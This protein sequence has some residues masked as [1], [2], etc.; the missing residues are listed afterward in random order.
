MFIN[1]GTQGFHFSDKGIKIIEER[2][3]AKYMG[4][5][6]T[7]HGGRWQ[8]MPVDVFYVENPDTSKG[9]TNFFGM[10]RKGENVLIT[11]ASSCFAEPITG[12]LTDTGEVV[13]SRYRHDYRASGG[14][15]IDGGRDYLK[16]VGEA[17]YYPKVRVTVESG[18]FNFEVLEHA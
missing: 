3:N 15:A 7:N 5:W 16:L 12:V 1:N 4:Y 17:V 11:D 10:F 18:E 8:E 13:V 14:G 6:C 9:H 2:Y